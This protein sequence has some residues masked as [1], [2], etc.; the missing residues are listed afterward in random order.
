MNRLQQMG[1]SFSIDDFGTGYSSLSY[2]K[3]LPIDEVKIDKSFIGDL[4]DNTNNQKMTSAIISIAKSFDLNIVA[5]GVETFEQ[6]AF[7]NRIGC[8]IYQGFYFEEALPQ[9]TFETKYIF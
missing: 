1:I 4:S 3:V 2:L 9:M 8:D 5:E 6:I 7:L